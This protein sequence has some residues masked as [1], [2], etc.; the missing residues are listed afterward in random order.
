[1][2]DDLIHALREYYK[3]D[4][5]DPF[6]VSLI[7]EVLAAVESDEFPMKRAR[8]GLWKVEEAN[9]YTRMTWLGEVGP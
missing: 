9:N 1:M 7:R 2:N 5:S 6:A 3:N 8:P 4:H